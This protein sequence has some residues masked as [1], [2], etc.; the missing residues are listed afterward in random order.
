LD[1]H[2]VCGVSDVDLG[3]GVLG[4][5]RAV[6]VE[7]KWAVLEVNLGRSA[8]TNGDFVRSCA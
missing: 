7:G 8:V 1:P 3:V 2:V 6:I 4:V 5:V